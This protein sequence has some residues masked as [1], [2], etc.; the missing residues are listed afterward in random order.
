MLN[1]PAS[2]CLLLMLQHPGINIK[3]EDFFSEVWEKHGQYVTSNTF[4]QNISLIRKGLRNAGLK[5]Q[6]IKTVPRVGICFTGTVQIISSEDNEH[7]HSVISEEVNAGDMLNGIEKREDTKT[8]LSA[9]KR[10]IR[11]FIKKLCTTNILNLLLFLFTSLIFLAFLQSKNSWLSEKSVKIADI[12]QCS[13][14]VSVDVSKES[15]DEYIRILRAKDVFCGPDEFIRIVNGF[16]KK[17]IL[18]LFCKNNGVE[19]LQCSTRFK[20]SGLKEHKAT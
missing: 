7:H 19:E 18:V 9:S 3:R 4:Y 20:L 11:T 8:E 2:R 15:Y 17:D 14:Y 10:P 5:T 1:I 6:V 16:P 13:V 12:N